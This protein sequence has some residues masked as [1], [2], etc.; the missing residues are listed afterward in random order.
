MHLYCSFNTYFISSP[1]A[2]ILKHQE[3]EYLMPAT[4]NTLIS[5]ATKKPAMSA[6]FRCFFFPLPPAGVGKKLYLFFL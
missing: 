6:G 1:H 4:P 5:N 2:L 3:R